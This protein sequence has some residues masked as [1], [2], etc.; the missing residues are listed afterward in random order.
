MK[1]Y[2]SSI[3]FSCILFVVLGFP[4]DSGDYELA[5]S[6]DAQPGRVQIRVYRGPSPSEHHFAPWG[7]WVKQPSADIA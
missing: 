1:M 7:F 6:E 4:Q 3:I 2:C 5:A